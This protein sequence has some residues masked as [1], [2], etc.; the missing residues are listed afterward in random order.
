V[1]DVEAVLCNDVIPVVY[2]IVAV[3]K[4]AAM[5]MWKLNS[6]IL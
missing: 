6:W 2:K 3:N 1:T 5:G 4:T